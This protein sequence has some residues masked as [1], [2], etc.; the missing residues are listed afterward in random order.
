MVR[1]VLV[2]FKEDV[3]PWKKPAGR[4]F[5]LALVVLQ[6]LRQGGNLELKETAYGAR[7]ARREKPKAP[8]GRF[9]F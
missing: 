4:T 7:F 9:L 8:C 6:L 1:M 5:R 2:T 3:V